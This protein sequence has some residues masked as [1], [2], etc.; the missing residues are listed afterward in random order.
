[1]FVRNS[2]LALLLIPALASAQTIVRL[3][4][5]PKVGTM[6]TNGDVITFT[7]PE[8][9]GYG[10]LGVEARGTWTGTVEIQCAAGTGTFVSLSLMPRDGTATVTS[11]TANGQWSASVAGCARLQATATA[12]MTGTVTITMLGVFE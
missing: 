2:L 5:T 4:A 11:F 6:T 9:L 3:G 8:G 10:S 1:M 7:I 12:A